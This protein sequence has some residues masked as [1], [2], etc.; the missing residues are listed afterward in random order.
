MEEQIAK[1]TIHQVVVKVKEESVYD[2]YYQ[3]TKQTGLEQGALFTYLPNDTLDIKNQDEMLKKAKTLLGARVAE[4][5]V[6]NSC[7]TAYG[8]KKNSA[9]N[10]IKTIVADG[11]DLKS[12]SKNGQNSNNAKAKWNNYSSRTNLR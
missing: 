10:M 9:F 5:I 1:V 7:S 6:T 11:I 3:Q 8:W 2:Q 4:R 12:L